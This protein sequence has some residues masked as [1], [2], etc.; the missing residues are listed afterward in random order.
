MA[1]EGELL[2]DEELVKLIYYVLL[3]RDPESNDIWLGAPLGE[4][5]TVIIASDE[6]AA[7]AALCLARNF[8]DPPLQKSRETRSDVAKALV[9]HGAPPPRTT[10]WLDLLSSGLIW[11]SNS[12]PEQTRL[13]VTGPMIDSIESS[14][15]GAVEIEDVLD[16]LLRF[17]PEWVRAANKVAVV[18][19]DLSEADFEHYVVQGVLNGDA[20]LLPHFSI[21]GPLNLELRTEVFANADINS[22]ASLIEHLRAA[23]RRG[24]VKHW[25][26]D[27]IYYLRMRDKLFGG[28]A[29]APWAP[30]RNPYLD[31]IAHGST[32]RVRPHPL[33]CFTAYEL[34]NPSET[35]AEDLFSDYVRTGQ[36]QEFRTSALFDP[37]F[38]IALNA[39]ILIDLSSG[40]YQSALESF[41]REGLARG[42]AFSPDFDPGFYLASGPKVSQTDERSATNP[43]WHFLCEGADAG[44]QAN[45]YFDP[46]YY[47]QRY[48]AAAA[49]CEQREIAPI[50]DFLLFGKEQ[51]LKPGKPLVDRDANIL[52]AKAIYERRSLDSLV[53]LSRNPLDFSDFCMADPI[54][55]VVVPVHNQVSFTARFLEQA[56]FACAELKRSTGASS[57]VIIVSNGSSDKTDALIR[58]IPGIKALTLADAI[59]FTKAVNHGAKAASGQYLLIA[60]NDIEFDPGIFRDLVSSFEETH[61][62]G[63]LGARIL[64]MDMTIQELGSFISRDGSTG[65]HERGSR[66]SDYLGHQ[67][68]AVDYVSGCFLC[69]ER[70]D[71]E[72]LEGFDEV[73][74]PGYYEEVD[75]CLRMVGTLGKQVLVDPRLSVLHYENASYMQGRPPAALYPLVLR[76]RQTLLR[77]HPGISQRLASH[78]RSAAITAEAHV[79]QRTKMLVIV[80]TV[81]DARLGCHF[82]R[83]AHVLRVFHELDTAYEVMVLRSSENIDDYE[84]PYVRVYR[85]WMPSEGIDTVLGKERS[86]YSHLWVVSADILTDLFDHLYRYR[87]THQATIIC[88]NAEICAQTSIATP[89]VD[90]EDVSDS[91]VIDL[92]A[93]EFSLAA[94]VDLLVAPN[95]RAAELI[96]AAG[97]SRVAVVDQQMDGASCSQGDWANDTTYSESLLRQVEAV[98]KEVGVDVAQANDQS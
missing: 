20:E 88:D 54:L 69:L 82:G 18:P 39:R 71:F 33:F 31:F 72:L 36:F 50:E 5:A 1:D 29:K 43:G 59:G 53:R 89:K 10:A 46:V 81:P 6:F 22:I 37:R 4:A 63:V 30:L 97:F 13:E 35:P 94:V 12:L 84:F 55:S 11:L 61:D 47:L 91:E 77:K 68:R 51:C 28:L 14:D 7:I 64:S 52:E 62:C 78:R 74:A 60:N 3:G 38:Y 17:D 79:R 44:L 58:T 57:E 23:V 90:C 75:L 40:R 83:T 21:S 87:T 19:A 2:C 32:H 95:E 93:A 66:S 49:R 80:D 42:Y 27:E 25:L 26:F 16:E 67:K 98:L 65:G 76:N 9:R 73:F 56:Y 70:A 34:L 41:C 15:V 85:A 86:P 48:P 8:P 96:H 24:D 92:L 45:P